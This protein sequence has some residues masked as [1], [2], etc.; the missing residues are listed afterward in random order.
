M[1]TRMSSMVTIERNACRMFDGTD[2]KDFKSEREREAVRGTSVNS[3]KLITAIE[4]GY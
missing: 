4:R 3:M 2:L 1:K